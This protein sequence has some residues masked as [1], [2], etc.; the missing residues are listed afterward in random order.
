MFLARVHKPANF[1]F[2]CNEASEMTMTDSTGI[3]LRA[4]PGGCHFF[5]VSSSGSVSDTDDGCMVLNRLI[6][7]VDFESRIPL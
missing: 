2:P 4:A 6:I 7:K 3:L 5:H 1:G